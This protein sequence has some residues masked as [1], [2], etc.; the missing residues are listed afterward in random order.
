MIRPTMSQ[1]L[2]KDEFI[3]LIQGY[4]THLENEL[5]KLK[6]QSNKA[7]C[8]AC[9]SDSIK[10]IF[11]KQGQCIDSS[12]YENIKDEFRHS[13]EYEI[14]Y[15]VVASKDHMYCKCNNCHKSWHENI[16]N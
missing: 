12:S 9:S 16:P 2:N 15:K 3:V 13:I 8:P 4:A 6:G 7:K 1:S 10:N 11:I 5:L 14:F